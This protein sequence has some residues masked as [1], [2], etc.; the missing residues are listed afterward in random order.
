MIDPNRLLAAYRRARRDLLARRGPGGH[1]TGELSRSALSTATATSALALVDRHAAGAAHAALRRAGL[2]WLVRHVNADGGW[3]DTDRSHSN[4]AT[5]MLVQ[6]AFHLGDAADAHGDLLTRAQRYV[7]AQGGIDG[8]RRRYGIDKTFAVPILTN[9]ALAGLAPWDAVAPLPFELACCPRPMLRLLHLGVVSYALPALVAIGQ[10][11]FFH[12]R[13]RHPLAWLV[14]RAAIGPSLRVLGRMQP[15]SGGFLEAA[16]LTS[17][18][19]MSLAA[20][21]RAEHPV[22]RRGA[23]FL[24]DSVRPDGGWPIDVNLATWTTTLAIS[25]LAQLPSPS[26]RGAGGEGV[27]LDWL[28]SCQHTRV[29]P[30]TGAAPGGWGWSD[31]GGAVPDVD[32]TSGALLALA[33]MAGEADPAQTERI[34]AATR[35]G[36]RWL[37][38]VQ[39]ADGGWPT[40]CRGWGRLPF[41]R[42]ATDLT[43]HALRALHAYRTICPARIDR[44]VARGWAFLR[45]T[46]RTDGAWIPLWFGNQ[47]DPAEENPVYGTSRVLAACR[48]LG[49]METE[50]ARRAVRWLAAAANRD[51]GWGGDGHEV[52]SVEE[53][54]LAV[55]ALLG[56]ES[57]PALQ[58]PLQQGLAWLVEAVEAGRHETPSPIGLYFARLWYYEAMYPLVF[59]V[60]ALGRAVARLIDS[61]ADPH[62]RS[63]CG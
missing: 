6:A 23:D 40:F 39:N 20:T 53:T 51:G 11:R 48:A 54:A 50:P 37:L 33:A 58:V 28:L 19:V 22:A 36:I 61:P 62:T 27:L 4:I 3:G 26:G 18:V 56:A 16:P 10:A 32:D 30:F 55:E 49:W 15:E 21:G 25:A 14:R 47:H 29:H 43:A 31:L 2:D 12:S 59:T 24:R 35:A 5:T 1:W 9:A 44:A 8:L 41:D 17:F 45:R 7:D 57:E 42:S 60:A 63:H 46:Q 34:A 13:P 52:S 38:D